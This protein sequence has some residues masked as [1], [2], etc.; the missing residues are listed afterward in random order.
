MT[1]ETSTSFQIPE[2][3]YT[4]LFEAMPGHS[5]LVQTDDPKFT[6][7]A[8]TPAYLQ[9]VGFTK[10]AIIGK[11]IFEVFP[12]YDSN[13]GFTGGTDLLLASFQHVVRHKEAHFIPEHRYDLQNKDG[14]FIEKYWKISNQP[15]FSP[16][17]EIVYLIHTAE[18]ITAQ[19]KASQ[20]EKAHQELQ[21]VFHHVEESE[22]RFRALV[23]ATSDVVY[24]MNADW[25]EMRELQ[26]RGFLFDTGEPIRNWLQ[27]YIQS[28][29]Q[30]LVLERIK[31][32][33]EEKR[34]FEM[35]HQVLKV[36]G[37][38][39]WTF[40]RAVPI[41]D[42]ND[43]VI[44]WFGAASDITQRKQAEE[45]LR[46]TKE[47]AERQRRL[48]ETITANTP[49]LIYVFDLNY[50][51][52]YAN[53]ALLEMWGKTPEEAIGK[54]LP[55]NGYEPWHVELHQREIDHVIATRQSIRGEVSFP[56]AT[57]GRRVYDYIFVPVIN[58]KGEVE[59][60][61][62]TTRD[63]TEI[64]RAEEALRKSE[65]QQRFLLRLNDQLKTL[66]DTVAIQYEAASLVGKYFGADRVGYAED[67]GDGKTV[68]VTTDYT[69]GVSSLKGT[70][71]YE[72]YGADLLQALREGRTIIRSDIA[73][74]PSFSEEEKAA[75]ATLQLGA[76]VNVPL[77]RDGALVAIFFMHY[78]NAHHWTEENIS[79]MQEVAVRTW[80]AVI[81]ARAEQGLRESEE[82]FRI[83]AD[84][85]PQ[86]M[87]ITDADGRT[88]FLNK[89]WCDYCGVPYSPT[90]AADIAI[91]HLHPDDAPKVMEA[92]QK[93]MQT[94]E[95]WEVE[96]R[97]RSKDGEYRW[98][99]NRANPYRDPI[100]GNII[101]WFGIGV[102]IHDRKVAEQALRKSEE[103]LEKKVLERT[104]E[105]EKT[106]QELKRTNAN[107]EDFAY[108]ASHDLK[109]PIRK[110]H[111]FSDRL[112]K[113]LDGKLNDQQALFFGRLENA[114]HRM[115]TLVDD[116]LSY[117]QASQGAGEQE[118][119]DLNEKLRLVLEDMEVEI[120][121][122]G[123]KVNIEPLPT[124]RGNRRQL[125]QLFHN[126]VSNALKYC[127]PDTP[128]VIQITAKKI[129][130][131]KVKP[132][133]SPEE[134]NKTF[135][136]LEVSDNGIGFP[137]EDA[138]RIFNI[139]TRLHGNAE[140]R[141]TGVGLSIAQKVVQN[142]GGHIWAEGKAG[143]GATFY[144]LLPA[145]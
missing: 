29:D 30:P 104:A 93:A 113:E 110:I 123:A 35:E 37:T 103:A 47:E 54:G 105:L 136:L 9:Q 106:N 126:L 60:I 119:A 6:M 73:A 115:G 134:E 53:K 80:D 91:R 94:G 41:L 142:H 10:K 124:V 67:G 127:Q 63:I 59:A 46:I 26:G 144:V 109:E 118:A 75:H 65:Q 55:E 2:P 34:I 138:K 40:S 114:A 139:F 107:L 50:R 68:H 43:N 15:V 77:L 21:R 17:G 57:L 97:N 140:Y 16:G 22:E 4:T 88:E 117:S 42:D 14:N 39:G 137:P 5:V 102:D 36:D 20:Q 76:T 61:A 112:K 44:E 8:A 13:P 121:Q 83:M 70:Y 24:R 51:F 49:D 82:R 23:T 128:P 129:V 90:A 100:T 130:G 84:A 58:Q 95:P 69:N 116:L 122:K 111:F 56:H 141:G 64:R 145:E 31:K 48:Y 3:Y 133:L 7:L 120:Q 92:F 28:K 86:S 131:K 19:I 79:L 72:D 71:S 108:A 101:K 12:S 52:T 62:G 18:E 74:D 85:V 32:A 25:T 98:F 38:L 89:H 78:R 143:E 132:G 1:Y 99:L 45:D 11:G 81:R 27:R 96:Q 125:Q 66:H 33:V 135:H 87:W